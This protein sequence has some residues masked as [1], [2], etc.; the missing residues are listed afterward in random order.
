MTFSVW[1]NEWA[2]GELSNTNLYQPVI[3]NQNTI[4]RAIRTWV[5]VY[6]DPSF[7]NLNCKIY[8]NDVQ[9]SAP[10]LLLYTSTNTVLKADLYTDDYAV[11]EIY[12]EFADINLNGEDTYHFVINGTGYSY[13]SSS[14]LAWKKAWP[15][16]VYATNYVVA[17]INAYRAPY[18]LYCIGAEL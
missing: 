16:P 6:N 11:R 8:S 17:N 18:A 2:S 14:Y 12:F 5:I 1:A 13:S 3:F 10:K 7:T 9:T 4:L 15:D